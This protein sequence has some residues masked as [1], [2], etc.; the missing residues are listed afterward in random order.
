MPLCPLS[1][2]PAD[3]PNRQNRKRRARAGFLSLSLSLLVSSFPSVPF[4]LPPRRPLDFAGLFRA[5]S[6]TAAVVVGRPAAGQIPTTVPPSDPRPASQRHRGN[7]NP[8]KNATAALN[9]RRRASDGGGGTSGGPIGQRGSLSLNASSP[10]PLS[11][12]DPPPLHKSCRYLPPPFA[13]FCP[14]FHFLFSFRGR[15][16]GRTVGLGERD[17]VP[18]PRLA[19]GSA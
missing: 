6:W 1:L 10:L 7:I 3:H 16:V 12:S 13:S 15:T 14:K 5:L 9:G 11:L 19:D 4:L 8:L 2:S 18:P 17:A